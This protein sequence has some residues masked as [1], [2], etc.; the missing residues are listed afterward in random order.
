MDKVSLLR[1]GPIIGFLVAVCLLWP[2]KF[3]L[4]KVENR[5]RTKFDEPVMGQFARLARPESLV[6]GLWTHAF[7]DWAEAKIGDS[8]PLRGLIVRA[9]NQIYYGLFWKSY[10][11]GDNPIIIGRGRDLFTLSY[12][13][14]YCDTNNNAPDPVEYEAWA[15]RL[16][17]I[18]RWFESQ[19]KT[20]LY[21]LSPSKAAY[22]A[23]DIPRGFGCSN[24][25]KRPRYERALKALAAEDIPLVDASALMLSE[26]GR[27]DVDLFTHGGIHY[28]ALGAALTLNALSTAINNRR[29]TAIPTISTHYTVTRAPGVIDR[30]ITELLNLLW[31]NFNYSV[32]N[33][34]WGG[35]PLAEPLP[36]KIAIVGG[37]FVSQPARLM[38]LY[39]LVEHIVHFSY[40]KLAKVSYPGEVA[41]SITDTSSYDPLFS[42]DVVILEENEETTLSTH[43]LAF[44]QEAE[45]RMAP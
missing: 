33:L 5:V 39:R 28:N 12:V 45:R 44:M 23:S 21:F 43:G 15:A 42:A 31:P 14:Q 4:D 30:D 41:S 6:A 3:T 37:S 1:N 27:A 2:A 32:P 16:N 19:G 13:Q 7:Q 18:R 29:G 10:M 8:I 22:F 36:I 26:R 34:K 38:S 20:F 9:T 35:Y 25:V 11:G 24:N 17:R 40:F